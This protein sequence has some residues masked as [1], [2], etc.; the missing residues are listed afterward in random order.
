MEMVGHQAIS[1]YFTKRRDMFFELIKEK[2]IVIVFKENGFFIIT[3]I[4]DVIVGV[5]VYFH[6]LGQ[7]NS[8]TYEVFKTS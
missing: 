3:P 7:L 5:S 4:V 1:I 6:L 8:Q 2:Q